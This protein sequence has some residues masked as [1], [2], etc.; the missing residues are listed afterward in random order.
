[1]KNENIR[2]IKRQTREGGERNPTVGEPAENSSESPQRCGAQGE[3]APPDRAWGDSGKHFPRP[4]RSARRGSAG[5]PACPLPS[6]GR[7]GACEKRT[8]KRRYG[9]TIKIPTAHL[10]T[11]T[12]AVRA[13]SQTSYPSLPPYGES[14]LISL[15]LLSP[16]NPLRWACAETP[17]WGFCAL[18]ARWGA[19]L[20]KPLVV[21]KSALIRFRLTAKTAHAPLLL[22]SPQSLRLCGA[23]RKFPA[24]HDTRSASVMLHGALNIPPERRI[25]QWIS[26]IFPLRS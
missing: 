4:C 26:A 25:F 22:L 11:V 10:C 24:Q 8:G 17:Y 12:G 7:A 20:P 21:A 2:V 15:L 19:T 5:V 14:S 23:P 9:V 1:M 18:R 13:S 3:D 16:R 6:A